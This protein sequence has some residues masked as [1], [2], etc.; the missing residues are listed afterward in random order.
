M[1]PPLKFFDEVTGKEVTIC[2]EIILDGAALPTPGYNID[3]EDPYI[4]ELN[5]ISVGH[6]GT[7]RIMKHVHPPTN[8][9][10]FASQ[11]SSSWLDDE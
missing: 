1:P 5:N 2:A 4:F 10:T 6:S 7:L 8:S 11:R 3:S 9:N